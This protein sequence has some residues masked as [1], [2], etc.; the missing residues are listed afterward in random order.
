MA[1]AIF[2]K[3][4]TNGNGK[5]DLAEFTNLLITEYGYD[6]SKAKQVIADEFKVKR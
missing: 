4:D 2:K 5:L 3:Y 1:D 6:A